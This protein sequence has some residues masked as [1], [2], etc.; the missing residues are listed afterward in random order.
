MRAGFGPV[1]GDEEFALGGI[2]A[3]EVFAG[4][5]DEDFGVGE[6]E[7]G[8]AGGAGGVVGGVGADDLGEM[9]VLW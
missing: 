1:V 6:F 2:G 5:G 9:V 4:K 8:D 7:G 3:L